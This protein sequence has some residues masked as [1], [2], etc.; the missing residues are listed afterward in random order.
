M[1]EA[2]AKLKD[3]EMTRTASYRNEKEQSKHMPIPGNNIKEWA[4]LVWA[5]SSSTSAYILKEF[6]KEK[7]RRQSK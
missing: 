5:T 3:P 2:T 4:F 7:T 6:Y 1:K